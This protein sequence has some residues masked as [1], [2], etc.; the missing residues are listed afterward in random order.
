[1]QENDKR[2][3]RNL[4]EDINNSSDINESANQVNT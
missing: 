1:M 4:E 3:Y 2:I